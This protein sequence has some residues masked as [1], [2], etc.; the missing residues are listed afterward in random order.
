[1]LNV[2]LTKYFFIINFLLESQLY[3]K[4]K[5]DNV[6][7]L[8]DHPYRNLSKTN[9]IFG[10]AYPIFRLEKSKFECDKLDVGLNIHNFGVEKLNPI[11]K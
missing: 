7:I 6:D 11:M 5:F 10:W 2:S 9:L 3:D 4:F 1:M 8:S